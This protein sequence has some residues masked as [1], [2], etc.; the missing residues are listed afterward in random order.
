MRS[1]SGFTSRKKL[2]RWSLFFQGTAVSCPPSGR[3]RFG[4]RP[5]LAFLLLFL[6]NS[7]RGYQ[8]EGALEH[9]VAHR[10]FFG[11]TAPPLRRLHGFEFRIPAGNK[12]GLV[13]MRPLV[14]DDKRSHPLGRTLEK[15]FTLVSDRHLHRHV[16][17]DS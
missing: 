14:L 11:T 1:S 5:S 16:R 17:F 4:K 15:D 8:I 12:S 9:R 3:G 6:K 7:D 2:T 13:Q 10:C